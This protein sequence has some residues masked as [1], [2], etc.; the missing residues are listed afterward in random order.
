MTDGDYI[1][2]PTY[3]PES[4]FTPDGRRILFTSYRTGL[5]QL[6]STGFPDG[7][8]RQLTR[9]API[10]PYSPAIRGDPV[11]FVRGGEIR[12]YHLTT[13]AEDR[14]AA[15]D[16]QLGEVS[17]D[18]TGDWLAAAIKCPAGTGLVC[19]CSNG[20]DWHFIPFP[21]TVIH[22]HSTRPN[23]SGLNSPAIPRPACTVSG[24]TAPAPNA[25]TNMAMTSA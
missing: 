23:R 5:P 8:T 2:H 3:F 13:A 10:H 1:N 21:R 19:G 11:F 15:F 14:I 18:A 24:V 20:L 16:G 9:G 4:S 12:R 17:P 6:F 25:F 7:E 22:P